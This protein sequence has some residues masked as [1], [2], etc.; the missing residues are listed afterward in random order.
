MIL[1]S[2]YILEL[3][4]TPSVSS[5]NNSVVNIPG[6]AGGLWFIFLKYHVSFTYPF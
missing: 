6:I 2:R 4:G 1:N 5:T 3:T